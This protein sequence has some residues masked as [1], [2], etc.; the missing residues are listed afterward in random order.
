MVA[1][2]D[3]EPILIHVFD[4]LYVS[5]GYEVSELKSAGFGCVET[6]EFRYFA[7]CD[8]FGPMNALTV[9]NFIDRLEQSF[10]IFPRRNIVCVCG[11]SGPRALTNT[12]FLLGSYLI[13]KRNQ[14]PKQVSKLFSRFEPG[15]LVNYRDATFSEPTFGLTLFD[16]WSGLYRG[17]E[18]GWMEMLH[19]L[20]Y[21]HYDNSLNGDLHIV[22]PGRFIAFRGPK[23]LGKG[24]EHLDHDGI[25]EFSASYYVDIFREL[26]VSAVVR[27]NEPEYDEG[28]LLSAG[29][30]HH[31]LEFEDCCAPPNS[32]VSDFLRIADAAKGPIAV[33]CKAGL[34][35]TGTLIALYM[36]RSYGF[37]ARAAMGWLRIM[38][39][40][41]VIGEQQLYL[42]EVER[43]IAAAGPAAPSTTSSPPGRAQ[44]GAS[45]RSDSRRPRAASGEQ[46]PVAGASVPAA[47]LARQVA[48]AVHRRAA[49]RIRASC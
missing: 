40:G 18:L 2:M 10:K 27:L 35:R 31:D 6:R 16:C 46:L 3:E 32:V 1:K 17:K 34:G 30:A 19:P 49:S 25:R 47:T 11:E 13:L 29:I 7:F 33:H 37:T 28:C 38:R 8:D 4:M 5:Q 41:S 48:E 21:E 15:L 12:V 23:D 44:S 26:D 24:R 9:L 45:P 43:C 36:M 22:V 20:E 39:P 14:T 42:C